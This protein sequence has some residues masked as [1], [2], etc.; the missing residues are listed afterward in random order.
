[1]ETEDVVRKL[2]AILS[3][4]AKDYSLLMRED[5][6][7]TVR[8]LTVYRELIAELVKQHRGRVVDSPG[9]NLL[10]E[11]PSV[12]DAVQSAVVI[13]KE[14]RLRNAELP[15]KRKMKFRI[16]INL[17]DVIVEGDRIYGDGVNIAARLES[18]ADPEGICV[19]RTAYDQI[20][21]K[22]P[23][24]YKYLGRKTVKNIPKPLPAYKVLLDPEEPFAGLENK[25]KEEQDI[26]EEEQSQDIL[27]EAQAEYHHTFKNRFS[28]HLVAYIGIIGFLF[29]VNMLTSRSELWFFW[30]AL[31]WG[32]ALYFHWLKSS[33]KFSKKIYKHLGTYIG[34]I[35]FLFIVNM[36][37]SRRNI[38]FHWP[39]LGCGLLIFLQWLKTS[40]SLFKERKRMD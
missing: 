28:K 12:V 24:G 11:F 2:A 33:T 3:A 30:P 13:Q 21:N 7:A 37:T 36:L 26:W 5:E 38:W 1:M 15:E 4:D 14:L 35:G 29:I 34:I 8:T 18:L 6:V 9:D 17:G 19:S 40:D 32:L 39:A 22:L 16:G 23:Y 25:E 27:N 31:G 10:A 20:E